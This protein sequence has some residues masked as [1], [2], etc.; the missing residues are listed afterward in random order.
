MRNASWRTVFTSFLFQA[1]FA[2]FE[3]CLEKY[4]NLILAD[5]ILWRLNYFTSVRSRLTSA[6]NNNNHSLHAA[7]WTTSARW[8]RVYALLMGLG[9]A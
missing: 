8:L 9:S 7:I 5:G 2:S 3:F 6:Y 4:G 1:G